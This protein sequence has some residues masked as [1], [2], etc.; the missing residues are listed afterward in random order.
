M[1]NI[2]TRGSYEQAPVALLAKCEPESKAQSASGGK[3]SG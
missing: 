3:M 2:F 1:A